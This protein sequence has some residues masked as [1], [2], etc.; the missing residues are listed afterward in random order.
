MPCPF[1]PASSFAMFFQLL[2]GLCFIQQHMSSGVFYFWTGVRPVVFCFSPEFFEAILKSPNNLRKSFD[3]TFLSLWLK[4]GLVTSEGSKWKQRRRIITSAFHFRILENFVSVFDC[5]AKYLVKKLQAATR[6]NNSLDIVPYITMCTLDIICETAMGLKIKAQDNNDSI[7]IKAMHRVAETF[8][9]RIFRPWLWSDWIFFK[10]KRGQEFRE[11]AAEMD[12]FTRKVISERKAERLA[13][14]KNNN[15]IVNKEADKRK[16]FMDLLLD[17]HLSDPKNFT[18]RDIQ[19]EVDS[20]MFAGHDTTAV[21][22]S[23]VLYLLGLHPEVQDRVVEEL[24]RECGDDTPLEEECLKRLK[25]LE[26]VIKGTKDSITKEILKIL[27]N[28]LDYFLNL[29][30]GTKMIAHKASALM[31]A[32]VEAQ[33]IYPPAPFIARKLQEDID[34]NGLKVPKDTTCMLVIYMLHRNPEAFPD[35][36][37][38]DPDRFLP[39]N[40]LKRHPFAYCPFSAGPRSCIGQKFAML[41]EKVI[42]TN[43]LRSF[44]IRSLDARDKLHLSA[45][46]VLRSRQGIR[47]ELTPR[48]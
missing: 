22:T 35:P 34:V 27:L 26:C 33:R 47:L 45:E 8:V 2:R 12:A 39:E 13:K 29:P 3:Y 37:V 6:E 16:A 24:D 46:M 20:F 21:G 9:G 18:E 1:S 31:T 23:W 38:F 10:T 40:C 44:K 4:D 30:D 17:L 19:E 5:Q 11:Q 41:E 28:V 36:E 25:Y 48:N 32:T 7:Y 15:S 14:F 42:I 43:I